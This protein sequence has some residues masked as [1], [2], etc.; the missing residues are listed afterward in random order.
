VLVV[1]RGR[2]RQVEIV[3]EADAVADHVQGR[4]AA[5][6]RA[7]AQV[8]VGV[9]VDAT[10]A[11]LPNAQVTLTAAGSTTVIATAV[12]D[13]TGTFR[14][15]SVP[16]GRY[17][18]TAAFE[19]FQPTVVHVT[20]GARPPSSLRVVLPLANMTQQVTVSS[21]ATQVD[22]AASANSDAVTLNQ[23]MMAGL[24]WWK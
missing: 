16:P 3:A 21:Q 1:R 12:A 18:V 17:D 23:D 6:P 7:D 19:G 22:T 9:A 24:V 14:F 13:A 2:D 8:V 11:V 5:E 4:P 15:A 20:V 10:A